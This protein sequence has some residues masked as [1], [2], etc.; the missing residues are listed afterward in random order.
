MS[1]CMWSTYKGNH[2]KK[3]VSCDDNCKTSLNFCDIHRDLIAKYSK[4]EVKPEP[5]FCDTFKEIKLVPRSFKHLKS[6]MSSINNEDDNVQIYLA[7]GCI[8]EADIS[9]KDFIILH[10]DNSK[11]YYNPQRGQNKARTL[12][13]MLRKYCE[14]KCIINY[15][16]TKYCEECYKKNLKDVP[17]ISLIT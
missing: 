10:S 14:N 2:C 3:F 9:D 13:I 12:K 4:I 17:K 8:E 15:N 16:G 11:F 7:G 1:I 6:I 5:E